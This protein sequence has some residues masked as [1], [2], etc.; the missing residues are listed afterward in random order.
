MVVRAKITYVDPQNHKNKIFVRAQGRS[1]MA[2]AHLQAT[3][4]R[5]RRR[6]R[7]K[8]LVVNR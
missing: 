6:K 3:V 5:L 7:M 2:H 1:E 8:M 4:R